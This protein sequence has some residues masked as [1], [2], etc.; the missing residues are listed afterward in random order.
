[1][2]ARETVGCLFNTSL[3]TRWAPMEAFHHGIKENIYFFLQFLLLFSEFK[4]YIFTILNSE[5]TS[6]NSIFPPRN[7]CLHLEHYNFLTPNSDFFRS[8]E[9][10]MY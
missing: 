1:M 5:F 3:N 6:R 7:L 9:L 4:I 8:Y 2:F 10:I